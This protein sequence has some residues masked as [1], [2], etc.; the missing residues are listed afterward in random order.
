MATQT[1]KITLDAAAL[2]GGKAV[3]LSLGVVRLNYLASYLGLEQF[4]L[5]N[6]AAY[7]VLLFQSLFDLGI[8]QLLTREIA[9]DTSRS[10]T[11]LGKALLLKAAIGILAAIIVFAAVAASGFDA[12][13]NEALALTTLA[14]IVNSLALTFL[15]AF[16]AHRKMALV[17]ATT[18][19]NDVLLSGLV[20]LVLPFSPS[21]RTT[22]LLTN[23][24]AVLNFA[25]LWLVYQRT[26]GRPR[27]SVDP[28]VWQRLLKEGFPMAVSAFGISVYMYIGP[29]V[30]R[31]V[32]PKEEIG[33][34]SA[35]YKFISILTLVPAAVSQVVYPI[36][37]EFAAQAP[38]KLQKSLQDALRIM[39]E[40][41]APLAV[42]TI[43][44]APRIMGLIYPPEY[45]GGGIVLQVIIAGNAVGFLAWILTAFLLATGRQNYCMWNS[46]AVAG[47]ASLANLLL[48]PVY[49]FVAVAYISGS[50]EIL[51]FLSLGIYVQHQGYSPLEFQASGKIILSAA[52]MGVALWFARSLPLLL[53]VPA[54]AVCYGI[55]LLALRVTGD[56]EREVLLS[57]VGVFPKKVGDK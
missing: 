21:V 47:A 28:Q 2:F 17:S 41:S 23:L 8:A 1:K 10:E 22:L 29:T 18:V 3:G 27:L 54:G 12:A 56:Q 32:R 43:M 45:A 25:T 57:L 48:V 39:L 26:V 4:G 15:S 52:I 24:V 19:L 14:Q 53:L 38:K 9:R 6:F 30:L 44:L 13:T 37:S 33:L 46:L 50:T 49:G 5:L 36:F 31:Y 34:F 16:Q 7:F 35:G 40:I 55:L 11:L 51:L 20:I 42:G